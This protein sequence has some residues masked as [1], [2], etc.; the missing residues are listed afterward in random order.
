M[1]PVSQVYDRN[2]VAN[3]Y[4]NY[5][6]RAQFLLVLDSPNLCVRQSGCNVTED[7]TEKQLAKNHHKAC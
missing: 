2:K 5:L 3:C 1:L 6:N 4:I 7:K